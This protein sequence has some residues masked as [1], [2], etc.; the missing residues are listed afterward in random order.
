M[1]FVVMKKEEFSDVYNSISQLLLSKDYSVA[2]IELKNKLVSTMKILDISSSSFQFTSDISLDSVYI[3]MISEE[4][5][6]NFI[7]QDIKDLIT[8]TLE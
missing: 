8:L 1:Y 2:P 4:V 7:L 3:N 5:Y 6:T